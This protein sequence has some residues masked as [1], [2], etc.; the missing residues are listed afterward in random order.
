MT[1]FLAEPWHVRYVGVEH[2]RVMRDEGL[3]LEEYI[4]R[5]GRL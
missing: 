2:A 4:S 1:G 3:C 5:Y